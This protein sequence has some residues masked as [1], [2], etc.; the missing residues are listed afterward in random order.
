MEFVWNE[1]QAEDIRNQSAAAMQAQ[2]VILADQTD[3]KVFGVTNLPDIRVIS[4]ADGAIGLQFSTASKWITGESS[5]VLPAN[6]LLLVHKN[7]HTFHV[8]NG[9]EQNVGHETVMNNFDGF[10]NIR[11]GTQASIVGGG[12]RYGAS[13]AASAA[14]GILMGPLYPF[15][16]AFPMFLWSYGGQEAQRQ[17]SLDNQTA[18]A[19]ALR[20]S[21]M[22]GR[23]YLNT[24]IVTE[25]GSAGQMIFLWKSTETQDALQSRYYRLGSPDIDDIRQNPNEIH[26]LMTV[27][28]NQIIE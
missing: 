15:L 24:V 3:G 9:L 12:L 6:S 26:R 18:H 7:N 21:Y 13:A 22:A 20:I 16:Y 10:S 23:L 8:T 27:P 25:D 5:Q 14:A 1:I 2:R 17:Q 4:R 19:Q 11:Y 28:R